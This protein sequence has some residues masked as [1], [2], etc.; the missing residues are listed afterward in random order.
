MFR[1]KLI[2]QGK[3]L[4]DDKSLEEQNVKNGIQMMA[5]VLYGDQGTSMQHAESQQKL[6]EN[7]RDDVDILTNKNDNNYL[8]VEDQ[9]GNTLNLPASEQKALIKAMAFHEKGKTALKQDDYSLALVMFL[10]ADN[11]FSQC[12]SQ[13]LQSVDNYALLNLDIAWCYLCLRSVSQIPEAEERLQK[14]ENN[15]HK[16]YGPNLERLIALKGS[17]GNEACLF[18]RLHLLQGVILF[19]K[20]RR[21]EARAML[22]RAERELLALKVCDTS[23]CT[24]IELGYSPAE[25]RLGLRATHGDVNGAANYIT[26]NREERAQ[27]RRD[28]HEREKLKRERKKLGRCADGKQYVEPTLL[29]MLVNMG[30]QEHLAK[31]ALAQANN[32]V[33]DSIQL[34]QEQ[35]ELLEIAMASTSRVK[36]SKSMVEQVTAMG[37]NRHQAKVALAKHFGNVQLAIETLTAACGALDN[38]SQ[39]SKDSGSKNIEVR[40]HRAGFY[41]YTVVTS[42]IVAIQCLSF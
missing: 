20:N 10:E 23:L 30:F 31:T 38:Q 34:I 13:I 22:D 12:N 9:A 35:P 21:E 6:V 3:V 19:H 11:E 7:T 25:A 28:A 26:R 39:N 37:F 33:S 2:C 40:L 17:T 32:I 5:V 8:Q 36:I 15:F 1:L 27:K 42:L 4:T 14:C 18:M 41:L 24:L 16:S 29:K